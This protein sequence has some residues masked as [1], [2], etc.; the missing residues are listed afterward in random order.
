MSRVT[1]EKNREYQRRWLAK[2]KELQKARNKAN[3]DQK[4]SI[5]RQYKVEKGCKQ[6]GERHPACLHFHHR[7]KEDKQHGITEMISQA[8]SIKS[9]MSEIEKC[10][11]LCANCHAKEHWKEFH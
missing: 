5:L 8:R 7:N 3:R 2:N 11:I 9:I 4:L 1:P 10:D 6:C